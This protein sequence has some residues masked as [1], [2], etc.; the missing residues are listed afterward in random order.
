M[1]V[2]TVQSGD[3]MKRYSTLFPN[4]PNEVESGSS[5]ARGILVLVMDS[6]CS[7]VN[8]FSTRPN[9]AGSFQERMLRNWA[10]RTY[11]GMPPE[12][13]GIF[14][15]QRTRSHSDENAMNAKTRSWLLLR[16]RRATSEQE[17]RLDSGRLSMV[18]S[19]SSW[20]S[21]PIASWWFAERRQVW[22]YLA[23]RVK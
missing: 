14:V 10:A 11:E 19:M 1:I 21:E 3:E 7:D 8:S 18:L 17:C 22:R 16:Q 9:N 5:S 15:H 12:T 20:G 6:I 13:C 4:S 23:V 2:A